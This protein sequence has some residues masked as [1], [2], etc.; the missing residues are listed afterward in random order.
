MNQYSNLIFDL[1]GT[2]T[3]PQQGI[4]NSLRHALKQLDFDELPEYVPPEFIGPPLQHSFRN[5]F[6]LNEKDTEKA[7]VL[8]REYYG[9]KGLYENI[10]YDGI[11]E[12]LSLLVDNGKSIYVATSKYVKYAWEI[13]RHFELD[14]YI[15]DLRGADYQGTKLKADLI[16]DVLADYR[17]N[18]N[19]SLMIGDTVY[20]IKG[21][22]E[23]G[24]SVLSVGYGFG[25]YEMLKENNPDYY[26]DTVS[27]VAEILIG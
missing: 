25:T 6:N 23:A 8:F 22:R 16:I 14:K 27:D 17:L 24:I 7:I 21:A 11:E 15:I 20:D 12:L 26:V 9:L 19:D 2:L 5:V 4:L 3:D 1:D 13:L 10:P 18:A